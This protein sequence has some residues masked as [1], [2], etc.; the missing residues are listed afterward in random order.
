MTAIPPQ[1]PG[2]PPQP[3]YPSPWP[4][5]YP[6]YPP[7]APAPEPA[8]R[9][10]SFFLAILF[11]L[12]LCVSGVIN[13]FLLFTVAGMAGASGMGGLSEHW[14]EEAVGGDPR[15]TAKV[16]R[17][18]VDGVIAEGAMPLLGGAGGTV[19][20]IKKSLEAAAE[21][22]NLCGVIL[23]INSP[24]GGVSDSD[25]IH[26]L[27]TEF[28]K[29][30]GVP[31]VAQFRDLAASGGY[32]IAAAC[33]RILAEPT[34]LT[35]SIGVIVSTWNYAKAAEKIG[36][37]DVVILSPNTPFKDI[38]SGARPMRD[39]E[40]RILTDIVEEMY[41]RFVDVVA[42]GR[43]NLTRDEVLKLADGRIYTGKQAVQKGLV[44]AEGTE[45]DALEWIQKTRNQSRVVLVEFH[46][47]RSPFET[48]LGTPTQS[49]GLD[50]LLAEVAASF[51]TRMMYLWPGR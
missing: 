1:P 35:G 13:L 51:Q 23:S 43:S 7:Y 16:V 11:F 18:R 30:H 37:Q 39:E 2:V 38:M 22:K 29:K 15:A 9:G 45:N 31:V 40:R 6:G 42:A 21:D 5:A 36:I 41:Q 44:D 50:G 8:R 46:R 28:K 33:D 20:R 10:V 25:Q 32:Y 47:P 14:I 3:G 17:I 26:R 19:T 48:L 4:Y 12:L 24:G 27:I 49:R 34:T